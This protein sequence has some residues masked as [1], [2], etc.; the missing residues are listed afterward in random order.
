[1][2]TKN[3][4]KRQAD[5]GY[6]LMLTMILIA[7]S[8]IVLGS[9]VSLTSTESRLTSRNNLY[10]TTVAA[11]EAGTERVLAEIN[12]D[13]THQSVRT[14][15]NA[16][17]VLL[18]DQSNWPQQFAY[19][20]GA[21][22]DDHTGLTNLGPTVVANLNSQFQGLY[23]LVSPFRVVSQAAP[24]NQSEDL[25]ATVVQDFQLA[26]IPIFQYAI[27]YS[28]DLEINPG[29]SMVVRGKVHSNGKIY[30]APPA[31]LDFKDVVTAVGTIENNRH[32]FDPTGGA[33]TM[34]N[35]IEKLEKVSSLVLPIG[36]DNSPAAVQQILDPPVPGEDPNSSLGKQRFF[37]QADLI[38]SNSPSGVVSIQSG[39]WNNFEPVTPDLGSSYSFVTNVSFYDY[40]ERKTMQATEINVGKFNEWVANTAV[41]G[42]SSLNAKAKLRMSHALN[43]VYA[44]DQR[45]Q[46]S[47]V[48]TAVR[49]TNGER[50][51][52]DG[53][54]VATAAPLYVKG[55]FN[56]NSGDKSVGQT[57]TAST[58]P[59][60]LIGDAVT[61]LSDNW[62]D[63]YNSGTGIGSR[64]PVNT[65]VNA[66]ILAGIVESHQANGTKYYSG[67]V[68]NFPRFLED[69]S[70]ESLTYNGSMVVMFPSRFATGLW[71]Y[72]STYTAPARRWAFDFN[73]LDQSRLPPMTP[74]VRKLVR[75]QW[76]VI[77]SN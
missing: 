42:G 67:G 35:Y 54:S 30:A 20:D 70:G 53:F 40:R 3:K 9:V 27:F 7:V 59:A 66:A 11:A 75:G 45:P 37:N 24:L 19:S 76:R 50:L 68:E 71:S 32:P 38:I 43:S 49:V 15:L 21:G 16:Y 48:A 47:S 77:A 23:G 44:I 31:S 52:N 64:Q 18:P 10:N 39:A 22:A 5:H 28:L 65:T 13:F 57:N 62:K 56:L 26:R 51:P 8:L 34:P 72:G 74:Q 6:A 60:A 4:P 33:K 25:S 46:S 63:T 2:R 61:V 1:M 58:K 36:M 55:H 29:A 69:W 12:R 41:Q 73:F 14:D 17:R